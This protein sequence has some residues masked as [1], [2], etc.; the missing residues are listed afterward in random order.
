MEI[1][2]K[3]ESTGEKLLNLLRTISDN[4]YVQCPCKV[5]A[6]NGNYVDVLPIINDDLVNQPLYDVKIQRKES[7]TAYIFLGV[8]VGDRGILRFFDRSIEN[9]SI[10]GSEEYNQDD[11]MHDAND[12]CFEL[13]F[14]PD[15]EAFVYPI[16]QEIEI[17]LKNTTFKLSVDSSGNLVI[18]GATNI[19]NGDTTINGNLT[20]N[21]TITATDEIT[22][23][24]IALSTHIHTDSMGGP[25]SAPN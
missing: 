14:L 25:T 20:V 24:N 21:G 2:S 4:Q 18:T 17:G 6:V 12:G 15:N 10:N 11:R 7:S 5:L 3:N 16:N 13:G 9:Y 1:Q 8:H 19:I 22:G 23:N